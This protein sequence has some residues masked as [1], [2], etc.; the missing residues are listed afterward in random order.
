MQGGDRS[1]LGAIPGQVATVKTALSRRL[2][3]AATHD[4]PS[5]HLLVRA[6]GR[7][8][9]ERFVAEVRRLV[10]EILEALPPAALGPGNRHVIRVVRTGT[11]VAIVTVGRRE[12]IPAALIMVPQTPEAVTLLQRQANHERT[13]RS[14][15]MPSPWA[16]LVPNPLH[17][18]AIKGRYYLVEA[19]L[20]GHSA[21]P[22]LA[23]QKR[24][25]DLLA[26][27]SEVI[28]EMHR[29]TM[30]TAVVGPALLE[31]WVDEPARSIGRALASLKTGRAY[32]EALD[33]LAGHL[34]DSL[35][36]QVL[37]VSWIH[38]DF[39]PGN[40]LVDP[41]GVVTGIVD[42]DRADAEQLRL[43]DLLH[44]VLYTRKLLGGVEP[45]RLVRSALLDPGWTPDE[46]AILES[47]DRPFL[48]SARE[49]R[50]IIL[51]Y[52]LRFA[53]ATVEQSDYF[54]R[55]PYWVRENVDLVLGA[56]G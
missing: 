7:F 20:P 51:L 26:H 15:Y 24:R 21:L 28:G 8:D 1:D 49:R 17:E 10:P 31:R 38:G 50:T 25:R 11:S 4:L 6:F 33:R 27:A 23:D 44:L 18:G 22:L 19:A 29:Q 52:W 37:S 14:A 32:G 34:R 41:S 5:N 53:A 36:G 12:G 35:V 42:W 16:R 54:V 3:D 46:E 48:S 45:G 43:H 55:N 13:L 30:T 9:S 2:R 56:T 47:G 40:L 39:W